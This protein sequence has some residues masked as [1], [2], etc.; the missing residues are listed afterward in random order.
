MA[1]FSSTQPFDAQVLPRELEQI[2]KRRKRVF[3]TRKITDSR[4]DCVRPFGL[5]LSGGGIRSATFNLG[6][7]Q[8]LAE[9]DLLKYVDYLSTVSG[10]GYMGSWLHGLIR[11]RYNG[12]PQTATKFLSPNDNPVPG[13]P[14]EDPIAFLRKY[15]N[16]P[17]PKPALF[18]AD[19]WVVVLIWLRNFLLNQLVLVP[20]LGAVIL[21][22]LFI[23]FLYQ[24]PDAFVPTGIRAGPQLLPVLLC[25][26]IPLGVATLIAVWNLRQIVKQT[27]APSSAAGDQS[28]GRCRF[29]ATA[30]T[31]GGIA[32]Q[33]LEQFTQFRSPAGDRSAD[34]WSL[35][36]VP[37]V[38]LATLVMGTARIHWNWYWISLFLLP[39]FV[40]FQLAGGFIRTYMSVRPEK[41]ECAKTAAFFH[42]LWMAPTAAAASGG[43]IFAT[44]HYLP[45]GTDWAPWFQLA[46]APT[47]ICLSLFGGVS[48]LLGL[49]GS[50]YPD[51]AREWISRIG[52][53]ILIVCAA[54]TGFF[55]LGV[56]GP[57][58]F[59]RLLG[60]YGAVGLTA[61]AGWLLTT[62]GGVLAGRSTA[63]PSKNGANGTG[64]LGWLIAVAPTVFMIGYL[65]LLAF[66][67]H[68]SLRYGTPQAKIAA[69]EAYAQRLESAAAQTRNL[70]SANQARGQQQ[71][72]AAAGEA[73][74]EAQTAQQDKPPPGWLSNASRRFNRFA[75]KYFYVLA[76][77]PG[78]AAESPAEIDQAAWM[79][80]GSLLLFMAVCAAVAG[81][82]SWRVNINEFSM[83]HMYKNRL[84]RCYLGAS[85]SKKRKPNSLTG[86]DP[87]DDFSI[88]DLLPDDKK[89]YYGPYP[90]VNTALNLNAGSELAQ[91]ERKAASF[92]FT[93]KFCGF[94][95][96]PSKEDRRAVIDS[97]GEFEV[98][99]YRP[100]EGYSCPS[101]PNLGTAMAVSGAAAN[102]NSGY[103]TSGPM[104]FLLTVFDARL[105]W[106]LGN[107]R[108]KRA[109]LYPGP[110]FALK[111]LFL[112][113][114]GQT[115]GRT[116]FVNL[117][118]GG[119][120]DNLGLYELVRRRCRYIIIGDGEQDGD[121]TFGSLGGAI[122]KC[123]ADFG[124]E[125]DINPDPIRMVA[126]YSKAHCVVGT[127][128]YPE[129]ETRFYAS[130][131]GDGTTADPRGKAK[132]WILYLKS[133]LT[134][135][136][137]VDVIEY[138]SRYPKFPHESTADQ[139][140]SESQFESYR[141]L[142]L[143]IIRSAFDGVPLAL[144]DGN[145]KELL[146]AF[147]ALTRKWYAPIPVPP[148]A[149]TRLTDAYSALMR[150]LGETPALAA[151]V[152]ELLPIAAAN[153][154]S[155]ST[156]ATAQVTHEVITFGLEI[157][158]LIENVYTEF[159]FESAPNRANPRNAG[160]I[161]VFRR[162]AQGNVFY[163]Q[164]W[165]PVRDDY[166]PLFQRFMADLRS[167]KRDDWPMRS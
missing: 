93:P 90:I 45:K 111:Y 7:L 157:I 108:W 54:W 148:D 95:P 44:W 8:G 83:H 112:E 158:Q 71:S 86:F 67:A 30:R 28:A 162:W 104:A 33:K 73:A 65:L 48:L 18:G 131:A 141:R 46:F 70:R 53:M 82:A 78:E 149:A 130:A 97:N 146:T 138:R 36:T 114:L 154:S 110:L 79:Q 150:R 27:F 34:R 142:G 42:V 143:H 127:I 124:V 129:D 9:K 125:I 47:L 37:L 22:L 134:G 57:W 63:G 6:I 135:D 119:H 118:D 92:V 15:S 66:A 3:P 166:Q 50:D 84:V 31:L 101:G 159:G 109:S 58:A 113:L 76:V 41:G 145:E 2:Q 25:I 123:R 1:Q 87:A 151:L 117:S 52:A 19:I 23:G 137:P 12:D 5:A 99:G 132:G 80:V 55:L 103:Q 69:A 133:S 43:L 91:Q 56:F 29:W 152:P 160:W 144:N 49:M 81:I 14:E 163:N 4:P 59:A 126:N 60:S 51:G 88:A 106:W 115:T 139:F 85:N 74:M 20:A 94:A 61:V 75:N 167:G 38:F 165:M 72:L 128:E 35:L 121:L 116:K 26:S 161:E 68:L 96:S 24:M 39:L 102:P 105:G 32:K 147:Q 156:A 64:M 153:V 16:Y 136:E 98:D 140:F 77:T 155:G 62:V 13:S 122:R 164:V 21:L 10:G 107:P 89:P 11:N 17:A 100:T 120:F 40:L